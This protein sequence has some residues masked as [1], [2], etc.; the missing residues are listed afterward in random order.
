MNRKILT[1][2]LV[3]ALSIS[4]LSLSITM[5]LKGENNMA[6]ITTLNNGQSG[7]TIRGSINTNFSNLN[8][9]HG[10]LATL[11]TSA[12]TNFVGAI[13]ELDAEKVQSIYGEMWSNPSAMSTLTLAVAST[14]Y[15]YS[16]GL[17]LK[18]G[19]G[20][21]YQTSSL[22]IPTTGKYLV[23]YTVSVGISLADT[24]LDIGIL[25]NGA[26]LTNGRTYN[27]FKDAYYPRTI[28]CTFIEDFAA[29]DLVKIGFRKTSVPSLDVDTYSYHLTITKV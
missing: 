15:S 16:S 12:K 19:S 29:N 8:T 14:W 26:S 27:V 23:S 17:E 5:A 22:K 2:G 7:S 9:E 20:I 10:D 1:L 18:Y 6:T 21:T 25:K 28:S 13:N 3:C 11:T 4:A 24:D